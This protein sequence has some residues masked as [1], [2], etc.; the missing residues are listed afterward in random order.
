MKCIYLFL[1]R[2]S[3]IVQKILECF[4]AICILSG[5]FS[6]F[7]QVIYRYII[8]KFVSFSFPFTE[9]FARYTIVWMTYLLAGVCLKEGSLVSLN[10]VYDRVH[11][12]MKY[13]LYYATRALMI[14]FLYIIIRYGIK[15]L[16]QALLYKSPILRLSGLYLYMMPVLGS[17]LMLYETIVD[18]LGVACKEIAPFTARC[19]PE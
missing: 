9:E 2:I 7:F 15:Y 1:N 13:V 6:V 17:V 12:T 10:L 5:L 8:V 11:G 4:A 16:P 3:S 19:N 14:L 18:I